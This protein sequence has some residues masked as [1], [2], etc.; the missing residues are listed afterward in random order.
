MQISAKQSAA[1]FDLSLA[2][3][4]TLASKKTLLRLHLSQELVSVDFL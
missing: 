2:E 3:S 1:K 4:K